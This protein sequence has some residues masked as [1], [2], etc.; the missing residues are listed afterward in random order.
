VAEV[1]VLLAGM[2]S[3][4]VVVRLDQ[5]TEVHLVVVEAV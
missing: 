3:L 2:A 4:A 5:I 1:A